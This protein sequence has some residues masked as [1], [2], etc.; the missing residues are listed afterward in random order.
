MKVV[1]FAKE[2]NTSPEAVL[3][4]LRSLKLK[5]KDGQQ[6]LNSVVLNV[7]RSD[8][9]KNPAPPKGAAKGK[10]EVQAAK[11]PDA[12]KSAPDLKVKKVEEPKEK[13]KE[14]KK[15]AKPAKVEK[16]EKVKVKEEPP[17]P[18]KE[19][20]ETKETKKPVKETLPP[21]KA[22]EK[23]ASVPVRAPVPAAAEIKPAPAKPKSA[24]EPFVTLKPLPKKR[25]K[26]FPGDTGSEPHEMPSFPRP[27]AVPGAAR[28]ASTVAVEEKPA[29]Q[30]IDLEINVPITVK[31]FSVRIQQKPSVVLKQLMQMGIM[32]NIN[33]NLPEEI[34]R[35]LAV[36]FGF[37]L[38]KVKTQE[39]QLIDLHAL[40]ES[41]EGTLNPRAPVV[42]FMG[43]VDHGKTSLLD[44]IRKTKVAEGEHGGITQHIGAYSVRLSKGNITFLD[45]PG[46]EA[47]TAMRARG[48]RI[49]D[50]VVLVVAA[51]EGIMPQTEEALNHAQ[52]ANV[53]III[54]LNKIDK[55]SADPDRVKK[56]LAEKGLNP[57]D[58]GG[59]SP[60]F[61]L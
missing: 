55:K 44:K 38:T 53:P 57:E 52:A 39:Q 58:W 27:E 7:L 36:E 15:P 28:E 47:F 40:D 43:H 61:R 50:L 10:P 19:I 22:K 2:L 49:T 16:A 26:R 5:A 51:D 45:T 46:H 21:V 31:D 35:K 23:S 37:N 17:A 1:D 14:E 48:A 41:G 8:F 33:L 42:T 11:K 54:A 29:R 24:P 60:G 12:V 56:Q 3:D 32:A 25:K 20:K 30:L 18:K 59:S 9:K 6:E 13:A 34:V 4:R